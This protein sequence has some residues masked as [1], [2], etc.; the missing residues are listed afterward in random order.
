MPGA[1][2]MATA[3]VRGG[4]RPSHEI[5]TFP[6][7]PLPRRYRTRTVAPEGGRAPWRPSPNRTAPV[8]SSSANTRLSAGAC[9][10]AARLSS[11]RQRRPSTVT[12]VLTAAW[13]ADRAREGAAAQALAQRLTGLR[14]S[15]W[16]HS[17]RSFR[18]WRRA[19]RVQWRGRSRRPSR[20]RSRPS[21]QRPS[22]PRSP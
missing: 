17:A 15:S 21:V 4:Q 9:L 11:C 2:I 5:S 12:V 7:A 10:S 14:R 18:P 1:T 19:T 8:A 16:F 13:C 3:G 22:L 20:C 6:A